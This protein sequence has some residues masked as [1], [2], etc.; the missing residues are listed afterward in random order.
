MNI[1]ISFLVSV[2]FL[3]FFKIHFE[4]VLPE[5]KM[6]NFSIFYCTLLFSICFSSLDFVMVTLKKISRRTFLNGNIAKW[7]IT[8]SHDCA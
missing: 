3:H 8:M 7:Q 6:C 2:S 1:V 4:H 5:K